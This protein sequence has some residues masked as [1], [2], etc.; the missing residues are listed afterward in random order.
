[1]LPEYKAPYEEEVGKNPSFEQMQILVSR[2]KTRPQFPSGWGGGLVSKIA[3]E[4]CEDCWDADAEARLTALC[5]EE[6]ILEMSAMRPR[7]T[8]IPVESNVLLKPTL[9]HRQISPSSYTCHELTYQN[10]VVGMTKPP[11]QQIAS[12][13]FM[14]CDK[15]PQP[16]P[17]FQSN[18]C[19]ERNLVPPNSTAKSLD[20]KN[21][22]INFVQDKTNYTHLENETSV[23]EL[24]TNFIRN[25]INTKNTS[26]QS[27]SSDSSTRERMADK[28]LKGWHGIHA[29]IQKKLFNRYP[30]QHPE[31]YEKTNL[32]HSDN[33]RGQHSVNP[34][35]EPTLLIRPNNLQLSH[36]NTSNLPSEE[37]HN[38]LAANAGISNVTS[39]DVEHEKLP[40]Q[41]K[42]TFKKPPGNS[43]EEFA[44][45]VENRY[46]ATNHREH[47]EPHIKISK[48]ANAVK[49]LQNSDANDEW[50]L[51]RQRS[52]EVFRDVFG[53]K[54]SI[55]RLRDPS[56]RIKTPGDVP[57]SV[58]KVRASKT[59]S[60]Y[61][62]R[63]MVNTQN[64]STGTI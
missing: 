18:Q 5:T 32:I 29:M 53:A 55:E 14:N 8:H 27:Q 20:H 17:T 60:L 52:L 21:I 63:M 42:H 3:Q 31:Q 45:I 25:D 33:L 24:L 40:N 36:T 9:V 23:E 54:G 19:I 46:G 61:D 10:N 43:K 41:N 16:V 28:K 22:R 51:K 2:H 37:L 56:Q 1:M 57:F 59:S 38:Q 49:N 13:D 35:T 12:E 44:V 62:D 39:S 48:S 58:R 26:G 50:Q 4:T 34:R 30:L 64:L 11:N 6:R 15:L 47:I 7:T